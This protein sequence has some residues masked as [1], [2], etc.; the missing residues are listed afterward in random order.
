MPLGI[1]SR[2]APFP[3]RN[4]WQGSL[5]IDKLT[6]TVEEAVYVDLRRMLSRD[7]HRKLSHTLC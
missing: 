3:F 4:P 2:F 7:L 1:T 6:D 5:I